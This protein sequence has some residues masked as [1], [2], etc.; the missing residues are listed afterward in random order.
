MST[1]LAVCAFAIVFGPFIVCTVFALT[2]QVREKKDA[3][4]WGDT[5]PKQSI[6]NPIPLIF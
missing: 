1:V 3:S 6:V 5:D 4:R 2:R